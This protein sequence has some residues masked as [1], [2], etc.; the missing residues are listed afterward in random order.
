MHSSPGLITNQLQTAAPSENTFKRL[1][2]KTA[3]LQHIQHGRK[4]THAS[5]SSEHSLWTITATVKGSTEAHVVKAR[6]LYLCC[7]YYSYQKGHQPDFP[8]QANFKGQWVHPQFWPAQLN[9]AQKKVVVIGSG[10]TAVTLVPEMAKTA[11]HVT[12]LQRTPTY[13]VFKTGL[14]RHFFCGCRNI[15]QRN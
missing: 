12:M 13:V 2:T 8:G 7:G 9:Y 5:W 6:F 3:L 10:A 14:G 15:C 11:S 1:P 4:V